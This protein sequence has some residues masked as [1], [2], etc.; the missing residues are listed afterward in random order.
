MV[1]D[2]VRGSMGTDIDRNAIR[3]ALER[4]PSQVVEHIHRDYIGF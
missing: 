2:R 4:D 1:E 3:E